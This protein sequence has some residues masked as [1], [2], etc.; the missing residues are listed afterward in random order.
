MKNAY[1]HRSGKKYAKMVLFG[2]KTHF[3]KNFKGYFYPPTLPMQKN[4][5]EM[6]P[7]QI[8]TG[9]AFKAPPPLLDVNSRGPFL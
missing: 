8:F 2:L 9:E 3:E 6:V 4:Q 7:K 5:V 1:C